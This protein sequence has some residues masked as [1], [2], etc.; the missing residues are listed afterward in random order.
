M[1]K[2]TKDLPLVVK[3]R[4]LLY[5]RHGMG[6]LGASGVPS[7]K[8]PTVS[9]IIPTFQHLEDLLK[10]NLQTLIEFTDMTNVE[11]IVVANGCTDGT[12][13]YVRSLGPKFRVLSF[14]DALG[15]TRATNE[16]LK[17]AQGDFLILYNNDNMLLGQPKNQWLDWLL[18]PF[19]NNPKM[20]VTG[21][22]QLHDDYADADVIIGFCL[23]VSRAALNAAGGLLDEIF[24]P[25]GG[26]DIDLCCKVRDKGFV[27]RQVPKEGKL[28]FSHTNTGEYPIW[29]RNNQTF[30]DIPEYTRF[31]VKRNGLIN[32]KRYNKNIK[33]NLG[34]GGIEYPGYL[35]VDLHDRRANIIMDATKLDF[36]ENS[37]TEIMAS[38]LFEH[39][40][41][42]RCLDILKH[43]HRILK[44]GGK[45]IMEMPDVEQLCKRF[46]TASTGERYGILNAVH[47]SVN[48]TDHG[49]PSEISSPHLFSWWPQSIADHLQNAGFTDI[50]FGPE[51]WPHP[52]SNM[53]V[54]GTKP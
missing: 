41:P 8:T 23:C 22:L 7:Q 33:L 34:S 11:V 4:K 51:I 3:N 44:P 30:K 9:I 21:P 42:Y 50:V 36:D 49:D 2:H 54:E 45:L 16:G 46:V 6:S 27:V 25:G 19:K 48:T 38:H 39:L 35:S 29:H 28:G 20:A 1:P 18:E 26:E 24:S 12:E 17:I 15:F 14:P 53:H 43:W 10:P 31:I 40:N 47:G 13:D 37:V 32:V 5:E 52:E